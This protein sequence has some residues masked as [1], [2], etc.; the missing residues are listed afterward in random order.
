M[1]VI[2]N[3]AACSERSADSRPAPGPF[4]NTCTVRMPTS[5]ARFAAASAASWAAN[6]VPLREP[7]KP[8]LPALAQATTLPVGSVIV[9]IVLLKRR[10]DV[11]DA[12][13]HDALRLLAPGRRL[14]R[15]G[16]SSSRRFGSCHVVLAP[17]LLR[18]RLFLA[19]DRLARTLASARVGVR[20]LAA[21]R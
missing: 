8:T 9:T 16:W 19:G 3:P 15:G 10:V 4:T 11:R 2:E 5:I 21:H 20:A 17:R 12:L 6:G 14:R 1:R 18:R 7:L 13:G